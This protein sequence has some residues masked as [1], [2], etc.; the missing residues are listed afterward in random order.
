MVPTAWI[1]VLKLAPCAAFSVSG[2][3][4]AHLSSCWLQEHT[5]CHV[6]ID[7][8]T[9]CEQAIGILVQAPVAHLVEAEDPFED[10]KWVFD[11]RADLRFCSVLGLLPVA[12]R[13]VA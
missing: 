1:G 8:T 13:T 11:F 3:V 7:Q 6:Q 10:Q 4:K 9:G 5:P 12:Q 2:L